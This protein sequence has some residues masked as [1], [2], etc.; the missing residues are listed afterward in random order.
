MTNTIDIA[1]VKSDLH[2]ER[3][4]QDPICDFCDAAIDIDEP[5]MY[6]VIQIW[7]LSNIEQLFDPPKRW[8]PDALRCP[9]CKIETLEPAT[10]GI[11]EACVITTLNRSQGIC[12]IDASSVTIVDDAAHTAGYHAPMVNPMVMA[13]TGDLGLARWIRVQW[14]LNNSHHPLL[15]PIWEAMVEQSQEVPPDL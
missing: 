1:A 12:S 3:V 15:D 14:F 6:D 11:D 4:G 9:E 7:N 8:L 2:G 10:E 13:D 5:V